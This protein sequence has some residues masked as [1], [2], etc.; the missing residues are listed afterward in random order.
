MVE[1]FVFLFHV[2]L[3]PFHLASLYIDRDPMFWVIVALVVLFVAIN[4]RSR[5]LFNSADERS[6]VWRGDRL[7][8]G[9][10][11]RSVGIEQHSPSDYGVNADTKIDLPDPALEELIRDGRFHEAHKHIA[12]IE[13]IADSMNNRRILYRY[14]IYRARLKKREDEVESMNAVEHA[15]GHDEPRKADYAKRPAVKA[16]PA[17][18]S[19][20]GETHESHDKPGTIDPDDYSWLISL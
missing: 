11:F 18:P 19:G 9:V 7:K 6:S 4:P 8:R 16:V 5:W 14:A 1:A 3:A 13:R 17:M 20:V 10:R 12:D 2:L 15:S